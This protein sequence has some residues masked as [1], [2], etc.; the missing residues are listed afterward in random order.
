MCLL[1]H[2]L[3]SPASASCAK[4]LGQNHFSEQ[5]PHV[6]TFHSI[7]FGRASYSAM[8]LLLENIALQHTEWE[9]QQI[10]YEKE[11]WYRPVLSGYV[12]IFGYDSR[13]YLDMDVDY[14]EVES[15]QFPGLWVSDECSF[16]QQLS[17]MYIQMLTSLHIF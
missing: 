15:F 4:M 7:L 11:N 3:L 8:E 12:Q 17:T 5:S 6:L 10:Y 2:H 13:Q 14:V 1:P 16:N 9:N